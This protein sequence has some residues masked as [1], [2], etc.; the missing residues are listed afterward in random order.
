MRKSFPSPTLR[1]SLL[2]SVSSINSTVQRQ[3]KTRFA[4]YNSIVTELIR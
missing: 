2:S 1:N 3:G 4:L